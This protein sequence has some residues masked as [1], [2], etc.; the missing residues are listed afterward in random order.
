MLYQPEEA[1]DPN[2]KC[3]ANR[4]WAYAVCQYAYKFLI[5]LTVTIWSQTY[6]CAVQMEDF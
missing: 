1:E 2:Q 4:K 3:T 5:V 6:G